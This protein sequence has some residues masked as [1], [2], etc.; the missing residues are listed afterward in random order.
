MPVQKVSRSLPASHDVGK[1]E[2]IGDPLVS[3]KWPRIESPL[4]LLPPSDSLS[5]KAGVEYNIL[6][7]FA[8][9]N[10][11]CPTNLTSHTSTTP[12]ANLDSQTGKR[13]LHRYHRR[14]CLVTAAV[15]E[16]WE[17]FWPIPEAGLGDFVVRKSTWQPCLPVVAILPASAVYKWQKELNPTLPVAFHGGSAFPTFKTIDK[18]EN[19]I[20]SQHQ[21]VPMRTSQTCAHELSNAQCSLSNNVKRSIRT[22]VDEVDRTCKATNSSK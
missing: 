12:A 20:H 19:F 8:S 11:T 10:F 15:N 4:L 16:V 7:S 18:G 2:G 21:N 9:V 22:N 14:E 17:V 6:Q 5:A 1:W 13:P 3:I